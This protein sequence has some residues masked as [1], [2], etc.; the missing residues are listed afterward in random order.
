MPGDRGNTTAR[1][2]EESRVE[3]VRIED[4]IA[5]DQT[6]DILDT[7]TEEQPICLIQGAEPQTQSFISNRKASESMFS[8]SLHPLGSLG[9]GP[10]Q[11]PSIHY[12]SM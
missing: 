7:S 2:I 10:S 6:E 9:G 3:E 12:H 1:V 5:Q 8:L 11:D 4:F